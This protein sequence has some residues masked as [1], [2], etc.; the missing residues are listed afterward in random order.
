MIS[1]DKGSPE[2]DHSVEALYEVDYYEHESEGI[3]A[4]HERTTR[5]RVTD[6]KMIPLAIREQGR[7]LAKIKR[8][9]KL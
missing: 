9:R 3:G 6:E 1:L 2:G 8:V 7:K 4:Y 5:V